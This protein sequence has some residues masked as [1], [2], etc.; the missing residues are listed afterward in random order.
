VSFRVGQV[1]G[2]GQVRKPVGKRLTGQAFGTDLPQ[3]PDRRGGYLVPID[4]VVIAAVPGA[5]LGDELAACTLP[6]R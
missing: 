6:P 3:D 1:P 2:V 4:A 5:G